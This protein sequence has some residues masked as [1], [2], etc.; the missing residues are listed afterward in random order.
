MPEFVYSEVL[1]T[2]KDELRELADAIGKA[3]GES[4]VCVV[5]GK[6]AL[7]ACGSKLEHIESI[8]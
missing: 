7:D 1:H 5:G 2:T 4:V 3:C 8:Q 6:T